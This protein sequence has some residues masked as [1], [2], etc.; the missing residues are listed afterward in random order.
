MLIVQQW[1]SI[2]TG[3]FDWADWPLGPYFFSEAFLDDLVGQADL[4][5]AAW[6]CAMIA[7][8]LAYQLSEL[9]LEPRPAGLDGGQPVREEE[10]EAECRRCRVVSGC[11][12]G[13]YL[14]YRRLL[15]GVFEFA[16]FT[17]VR[18]VRPSTGCSS[19]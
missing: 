11:G 12:I 13:S 4:E 10:E 18:L 15:S 17:A 7:C 5:N 16:G 6:V 1:A 8:G 2:L 19:E 14:D 9:E 3:P